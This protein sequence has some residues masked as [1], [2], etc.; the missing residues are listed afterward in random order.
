MLRDAVAR[1]SSPPLPVAV[2]RPQPWKQ[3][4][5]PPPRY[6]PTA[7]RNRCAWQAVA[8]AAA[9]RSQIPSDHVFVV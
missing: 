8:Q 3:S 4:T 6:R 5:L 1:D 9:G 7:S 2:F